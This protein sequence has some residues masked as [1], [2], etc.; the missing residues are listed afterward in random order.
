MLKAASAFPNQLIDKYDRDGFLDVLTQFPSQL[1]RALLLKAEPS[2]EPKSVV[3][4]GMGGSALGGQLL[5][6]LVR[7]QLGVPLIIH[8]DYFLPEFVDET[9]LVVAVSYSGDT[10]ETISALESAIKR[11]SDIVT[12]SSGGKL[13]VMADSYGFPHICIP[14][15]LQPRMAWAYVALSLVNVL[16]AAEL[17]ELQAEGLTELIDGLAHEYHPAHQNGTMEMACALHGLIPVFISASSTSI[18]PYKWKININENAKQLAFANCL[19]EFNH[20]EMTGWRYPEE[21]IKRLA[22]VFI[23][24][25]YEGDSITRRIEITKEILRGQPGDVLEFKAPGRTKIDQLF[26]SIYA[27]DFMSYY[28]ALLNRE[29]P[30]PV[31]AVEHL[32]VRL[33][34]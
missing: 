24:T 34:G 9:S 20:N 11:G 32:K 12:I 5:A 16:Q 10:T 8:R 26:G 30:A 28:L 22:L 18:L 23:R 1:R 13:K 21:S 33:A 15:G 2:R 14:R 27:G 29:N 3:V 4:A 7:E 6:D 31:D 19:P 17:F 25:D